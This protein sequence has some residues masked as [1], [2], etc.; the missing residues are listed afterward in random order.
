[1]GETRIEKDALGAVPVPA[2]RLWGA[3][4]QRSIDNFPIGVARFAFGRPVIRAFGI[5]K[6][7][8]ARANADLAVLAPDKADLIARAA[9]EVIDGRWDGEFPLVVFQTGS[10]TQ[11]NMNA[12]EV[13]ANRAIQLAG[14][15]VG[16]KAP[17]HPNDDVNR[18]Q[19][20]NDVFPAVMHVA[21]VEEIDRALLPAIAA[22][23]ATLDARAR[24]FADVVMLGRT[25]LQDATP[26]TLGQVMSGW[27]AQLDDAASYVR[28]ARDA[29]YPLALGGTAVGTGLNAPARF[30]EAVAHE[31]ARATGKPFVPAA[32]KFAAL[33]AHDAMVNAS[34]AVRTLAGVAMKIANDV[35]LY[36]SGP[37][38]GFGE[39]TIPDNEPGSSIMPG[40]I[41]PT[42]AE[43]LTMVA[44]QVFGND[45]AV[46]FAG[47]QGHFQLNVYK[48]VILHNTLESIELLSDA[49]RSFD[50]R[51]ARGIEPN[52]DRIRTHVDESLM[53]VT[54]LNPHIGYENSAKIALKAHREGSTL[55][56][57]ALALGIVSAD[58]FD[59]WTDPAAMTRPDT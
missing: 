38:A 18:S 15:K 52:L 56:Q 48:P 24:A 26:V 16:S 32:N 42:Q 7:A 21:T 28:S 35:R 34:A 12:N 13:I 55:R 29:L 20:S 22:L 59:R 36:A 4:T 45:T 5:V 10:G 9:Q 2:H 17:V 25:H 3:Q 6:Q 51:C 19:S 53:L 11:S 58:D 39:I 43:A 31:I 50:E 47:T 57:A 37:R 33:S 41:N 44:V 23:R 54:A 46:A 40:K 8:A 49:L 14:G 30:G 1:M 27:A